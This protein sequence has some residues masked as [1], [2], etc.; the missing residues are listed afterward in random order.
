MVVSLSS[1]FV[2]LILLQL[3]GLG[4]REGQYDDCIPT[5]SQ[6]TAAIEATT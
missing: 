1:E 2:D 3:I 4:Q 6:S 5:L